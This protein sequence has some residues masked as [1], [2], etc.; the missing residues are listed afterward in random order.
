MFFDYKPIQVKTRLRLL[1]VLFPRFQEKF[2]PCN[3]LSL[4]SVLHVPSFST[5][6]LSL[7]CVTYDLNCCVTFFPSH[8]VFQDLIIKKTIG[9]GRTENDLYILDEGGPLA[10]HTVVS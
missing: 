7:N 5:N 6:L 2:D 10:H 4:S 3:S 1:M 8:C 9:C